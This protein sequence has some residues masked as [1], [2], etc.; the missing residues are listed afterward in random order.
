M[1]L[2]QALRNGEEFDFLREED[3]GADLTGRQTLRWTVRLEGAQSTG[4]SNP[5]PARAEVV[6]DALSGEVLSLLE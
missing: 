5:P 2:L 1:A 3:I 4:G 6:I